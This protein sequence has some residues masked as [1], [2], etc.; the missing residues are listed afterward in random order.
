MWWILRRGMY[1]VGL[2]A[3]RLRLIVPLSVTGYKGLRC[4]GAKQACGRWIL[5][6]MS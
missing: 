2:F 4:F 3:S 1:V 6:F 5:R